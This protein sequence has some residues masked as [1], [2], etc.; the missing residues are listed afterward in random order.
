IVGRRGPSCR[1]RTAVGRY[2]YFGCV[3]GG[4]VITFVMKIDGLPFAEAVEY[5][6][7]RAGVQ[8]RYE[9]GGAPGAE[10]TAGMRKRL[11]DA[12]R[13]AAEFYVAQLATPE[14][15]AGRDFLLERDFGKD[16]AELFGIGYAPQGWS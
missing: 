11:L 14:A 7:P 16:A 6:A 2:H 10:G 15:K 1:R 12:H 8:L 9:A 4:E 3:E 13:V 5:L